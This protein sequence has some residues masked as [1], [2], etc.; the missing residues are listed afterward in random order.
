VADDFRRKR[1]GRESL[2]FARI[3]NLSDA[4]F[5]IAMTL[6]VLSLEPV[7]GATL[8]AIVAEQVSAFV[9]VLL[10][11]AV[12]ANFW[13]VHHRFYA[14]LGFVEPGLLA[15]NLL[16]LG[17][18]AITPFPTALVG[19]DP[20]ARPAVLL[21]LG[22]LTFIACMHLAMLARAQRV[23]AWREP[24]PAGLFGW[25]L[26]GWGASTGVTALALA[27]GAVVPVAG[28]VMLALTWPAEAVVARLAPVAY[29]EW[30]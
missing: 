4:L 26:G 1:Y 15:L 13:W 17:A 16:L 29:R 8:R 25:L 19:Q 10:T 7:G 12:V 21:Y 5:A 11:F 14:V 23:G 2:E 30:G 18:V 20:T 27:V 3:A 9:A 24:L 22:L 28:L 6:L